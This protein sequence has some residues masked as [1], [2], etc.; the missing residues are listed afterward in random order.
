MN[1]PIE[2]MENINVH[3]PYDTYIMGNYLCSYFTLLGEK[4][5][6]GEDFRSNKLDERL[7]LREIVYADD[8][9]EIV[10]KLKDLNMSFN[11]DITNTWAVR[12]KQRE[13]F[14]KI[15]KPLAREILDDAFKLKGL[16]EVLNGPVIHLR[17]SDQPFGKHVEYHFQRY[18]YYLDVLSKY[19]Y[20]NVYLMS[21][22]GHQSGERESKACEVYIT[23]LKDYLSEHGYNV[24]VLC[25]DNIKDFAL[26]FYAPVVISSVSS[27][28]FMSGFLGMG[29]FY[30]SEFYNEDLKNGRCVDCGEWIR[31]GYVIKHDEVDSYYDTDEIIRKL[32]SD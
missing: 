19:S 18:K 4:L 11:I 21:C 31:H 15:M 30:S 1:K 17:C 2:D 22:Q 24:M 26:M 27:Y 20:K 10:E 25:N 6:R 8:N 29:D 16:D 13:E 9:R 23:D 7:R 14:W 12:D 5:S 28:S 32:R 3:V